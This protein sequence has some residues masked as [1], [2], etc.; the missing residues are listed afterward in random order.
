VDS[1][2]NNARH[3][4]GAAHYG[5]EVDQELQQ[6]LASIT[7]PNWDLADRVAEHD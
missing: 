3:C 5:T 7:V 1:T 4:E 2:V 6:V